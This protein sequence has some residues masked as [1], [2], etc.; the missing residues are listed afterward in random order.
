[1]A[2]RH[3]DLDGL[4][5]ALLESSLEQSPGAGPQERLAAVA[6]LCRRWVPGASWVSIS[7]RRRDVVVTDAATDARATRLDELQYAAASGP[8]LAALAD[9]HVQFVPD[10]AAEPRWPDWWSR[11]QE[12]DLGL[13]GVLSRPLT[14][15]GSDPGMSLNV[16]SQ[17][18]GALDEESLTA[19]DLVGAYAAAVAQAAGSREEVLHL[20]RAVESNRQVGIA[21]G[22]L[23]ALR[24]LDADAAFELLRSTSQQTNRK[25]SE[26]A[27]VVSATGT[28]PA[29]PAR[30]ARARRAG[31][32]PRES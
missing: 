26:V 18:V 11:V 6:E 13:A 27:Q 4:A 1:M 23:M 28:L 25:L 32:G 12:A 20:R 14:A 21:T 24:K 29:P 9:A 2:A 7:V 8:C 31:R 30:S 5:R 22:V 10:L 15:R 17:H 3:A 16:Y 19:S